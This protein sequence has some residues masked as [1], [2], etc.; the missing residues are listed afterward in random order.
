[1]D[2]LRDNSNTTWIGVNPEP[3]DI[4]TWEG[5]ESI[6]DA[7]EAWGCSR[8]IDEMKEVGWQPPR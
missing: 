6:I 4:R 1:M 2:N 3:V 7:N 5:L 8:I